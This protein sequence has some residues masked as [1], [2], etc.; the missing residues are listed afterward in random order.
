MI[1]RKRIKIPIYE[2]SLLVVVSD[3]FKSVEKEFNLADTSNYNGVCFENERGIVILI[4][5]DSDLSVIA[6][7]SVHA[8]GILFDIV[9]ATVDVKND[10]P[11]AYLVGWIVEQVL[12][13]KD[14]YKQ[15]GP[16]TRIYKNEEHSKAK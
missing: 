5:P 16:K 8:A 15:D 10:E 3:N 1:N 14:K 13:V 4:A 9:G 6:H 12:K 2:Q 11:F 7:E